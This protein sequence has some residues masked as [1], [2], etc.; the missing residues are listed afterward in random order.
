MT[1]ATELT[2][3]PVGPGRD[4]RIAVLALNRPEAA[5]AFDAAVIRELVGHLK[6]LAAM[7]TVRAVVVRGKGKHFSAGADLN[8]MKASAQLTYQENVQD[9][10]GLTALF[11]ALANL[12]Q[13]T[14]A[15]VNGSAFGGAVGLTACCDI[16]IAADTARF[17]LSEVKLGLMPAV[18]VPYLM[19]KMTPG[20]LRRHGLTGRPFSAAEAREMGLVERVVPEAGLAAAVRDELD[21][22][23]QGSAEAQAKLKTLLDQ[24]QSDG[25]RQNPRTA[26]AIAGVRTGQAG[27]AGLSAFFEKKAPPWACKLSHD[28][29]WEAAPG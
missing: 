12:P 21:L 10:R 24:T 4:D 18:I 11:E 9:A 14:I 28:W 26:E 25:M 13:P 2:V 15:A 19:R 22:L 5:N 20:G 3:L 29:T 17:S 7:K 27:Q 16:A 23:L 8:W 6:E 1:G